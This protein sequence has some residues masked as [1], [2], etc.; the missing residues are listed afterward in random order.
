MPRVSC[1]FE[2]LLLHK[3][4]LSESIILAFEWLPAAEA[5][6]AS[7][8]RAEGMTG[9]ELSTALTAEGTESCSLGATGAKGQSAPER[10]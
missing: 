1:S 6:L 5:M 2:E 9:L 10:C 3:I 8:F 7:A 4:T